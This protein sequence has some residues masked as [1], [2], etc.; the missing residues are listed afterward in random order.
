M[1][2][3][4][5]IFF[6]YHTPTRKLL[7]V[8]NLKFLK[9]RRKDILFRKFSEVIWSIHQQKL[10][11]KKFFLFLMISL[12]ICPLENTSLN[13]FVTASFWGCNI[14]P[15]T[16]FYIY[17]C[18]ISITITFI[19]LLYFWINK[20]LSSCPIHSPLP[21]QITSIKMIILSPRHFAKFP[22]YLDKID[23]L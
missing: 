5:Q 21:Y 15:N 16:I 12:C 19:R 8:G 13:I 23:V 9:W 4:L 1:E 7:Q 3:Y 11:Q 10:T 18:F 2:T 6:R 20:K 14:I 22:A 17:C